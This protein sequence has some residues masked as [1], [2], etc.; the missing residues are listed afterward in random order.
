MNRFHDTTRPLAASAAMLLAAALSACGGAQIPGAPTPGAPTPDA[1]GEARG[2]PGFDTR[3]YPG[4][5][6]MSAWLDASPYRW[7]GFYLPAPCY[8]G[9]SWRGRRGTLERMGWGVAILF[10]GEQD[11]ADASMT[12]AGAAQDTAAADSLSRVD[13]GMTPDDASTEIRCTRGNLSA[14][15]G[16]DDA[17]EARTAAREEGFAAG[18]VIYLDVEPVE[19]VSDSLASYV[20]AWAAAIAGTGYRPGL[21]AHGR[22][23]D[24]LLASMRATLPPGAADP[25]LW[26]AR[27][28]GFNLRRGPAESGYPATI[29]QGELDID[30]AWAGITLRIDANVATSAE[31]SRPDG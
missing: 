26:V 28:G 9:T 21:Y 7:V 1:P 24:A 8:T 5:R 20:G 25:P 19:S 13:G 11:W 4:D 31:P 2:V 18:S 27:P 22:N 10:V 30:E 14:D 15:Q 12:A 29:W 16:R 23:A 3:T 17:A 6:A